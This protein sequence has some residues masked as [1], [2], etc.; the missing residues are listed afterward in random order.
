MAALLVW[1]I[2]GLSVSIVLLMEELSVRAL[3]PFL[4]KRHKRIKP[5]NRYFVG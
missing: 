2:V 4:R 1:L 5:Q 3:Y